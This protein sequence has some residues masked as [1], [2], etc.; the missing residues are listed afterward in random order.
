MPGFH[1]SFSQFGYDFYENENYLP[2]G[3][4]YTTGVRQ[5]VLD[6]APLSLRANV[7]LEAVGLSDE[8]MDR[9]ADFLSEMES[10]DY[11]ALNTDGMEEA[12]EERPAVHL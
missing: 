4:G 5:S 1:F 10:I 6:T 11:S 7:M 2:M 9:N 12:V 3:F 8:A